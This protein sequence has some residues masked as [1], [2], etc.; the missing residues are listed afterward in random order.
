MVFR[1]FDDSYILSFV[2]CQRVYGTP[3]L[4]GEFR[5]FDDICAT[6]TSLHLGNGEGL[7]YFLRGTGG[8]R[9]ELCVAESSDMINW[10]L[11]SRPLTLDGKHFAVGAISSILLIVYDENAV[12]EERIK[13][14]VSVE[15]ESLEPPIA[16]KLMTSAN[17]YDFSLHDIDW[18]GDCTEPVASAYYIKEK[19]LWALLVR[20]HWCVRRCGMKF[21]HDFRTFSEWQEVLRSDSIDLPMD[22]IYGV[23]CAAFEGM[24]IGLAAMYHTPFESHS[25]IH[26]YIDG[27]M[28]VQ[29]VYSHDGMSFQRSLRYPFIGGGNDIKE[30][31]SGMFRPSGIASLGDKVVFTGRST[32]CEHGF[33]SDDHACITSYSI[34]KD[35]FCGLRAQGGDSYA[36]LRAC[37]LEDD[38]LSLNVEVPSGIVACRLLDE[39]MREISG[40]GFDECISFSGD[41]FSYS[42]KWKAHDVSEV[43]GRIVCL[44]I[45][46]NNGILWAV[47]FNGKMLYTQMDA[48]RYLNGISLDMISRYLI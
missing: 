12:P 25:L 3:E 21:T 8:A 42:P 7:L 22:E 23:H 36:I 37:V 27:H 20:P 26:K 35:R 44:E 47:E 45:R 48:N 31:S 24:C 1:F 6:V 30:P 10:K 29:L 16:N 41:S 28:D 11:S 19:G 14:I 4:V 13:M 40:F 33:F 18:N 5:P 39:N 46:W 32:Q 9:N 43:I 15:D 38:N 2:R 17:G 34:G